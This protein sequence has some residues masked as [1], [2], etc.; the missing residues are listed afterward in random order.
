M[1]ENSKPE[2]YARAVAG[3]LIITP[4]RE[5]AVQIANEARLLTSGHPGG[6]GVHLFVGGDS[7]RESLRKWETSRKDFVVATPGRLKD[8]LQT[9]RSVSTAMSACETVS[10]RFRPRLS[11][12]ARVSFGSSV[13]RCL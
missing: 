12:L 8:L 13:P 9:V 5:L 3:T 11:C 4:T 1:A 6:F 10:L 2:E 7:K